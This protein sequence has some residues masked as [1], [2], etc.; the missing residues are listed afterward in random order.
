MK[1]VHGWPRCTSLS[2][3]I[4]KTYFLKSV[5]PWVTSTQPIACNS[6]IQEIGKQAYKQGPMK[7]VHGW[8]SRTSSSRPISNNNLLKSVHSRVTSAHPIACNN[9]IQEIGQQ[10]YKQD[11]IKM[12]HGWPRCVCVTHRVYLFKKIF[13]SNRCIL[14][15]IQPTLQ[16]VI[17]TYRI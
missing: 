17:V 3:L 7:M 11:P 14:G 1:M 9:N 2:R 10:A 16:L 4:L 6:N 13:G 12:V 8:P 5:H 15:S